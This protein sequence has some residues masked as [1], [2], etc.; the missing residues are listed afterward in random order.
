MD[1]QLATFIVVSALLTV[2]P[3]NDTAL[4]TKTTLLEGRRAAFA[5]TLGISAGVPIHAAASG[6]GLSAV[7]QASA[8]AFELVKWLGALYLA[9]VG[10]Q[11]IRA[12]F[13]SEAVLPGGPIGL[14]RGRVGGSLRRGVRHG[15]VQKP[16]ARRGET[17]SFRRNF[18]QGLLTNVLNPKVALFYLTFLP[19]F[20]APGQDVL[21]QSIGLGL[22]HVALGIPWLTA[23]AFML[24]RL[25]RAVRGARPWLE[26]ASGALLI[27]LGLRL[28]FERR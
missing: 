15:E 21:L 20:I 11:I 23:Y 28:A 6:L 4:V 19:Q 9:Y 1:A 3:G 7:L 24:D 16:S 2:L 17:G 10:L 14:L 27:G 13:A 5:T 18:A 26:R 8:T 22:I 25:A 12:S